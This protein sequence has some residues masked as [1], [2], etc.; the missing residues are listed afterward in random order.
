[1]HTSTGLSMDRRYR[2]NMPGTFKPDL[3]AVQTSDMEKHVLDHVDKDAGVSDVLKCF[4]HDHLDG[5]A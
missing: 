3:R 5:T 1:M 4:A 2:W